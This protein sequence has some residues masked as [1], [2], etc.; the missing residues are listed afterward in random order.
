[1]PSSAWIRVII[2]LAAGSMFVLSTVTGDSIDHQGLRWIG[3]VT[4]GITVLLLAFDR[5]VWR[6]PLIRPLSELGGARVIHG[7][8]RGTLHY[9][10]DADGNPGEQPIFMAVRQTY[11]TV[12]VRCYFPTTG[13]ESVS[14]MAAIERDDH[15]HVLRYVYRS[16]SDAPDR[17]TR[18]ATEGTTELRLVGR[19]VEEIQGA[20]Y[21]ERNGGKGTIVFDAHS[22]KV[23]GSA[24]QAARLTYR[25]LPPPS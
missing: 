6:W 12:K 22:P 11:S 13:S 5:L 3:G 16:D 14:L 2:L 15:R 23:A 7:T 1:M 19:P 18:R 24:Q 8:W 17:D 9:T 4:G 20:Y 10:R 25:D 21:V